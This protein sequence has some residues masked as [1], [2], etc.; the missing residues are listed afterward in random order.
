VS[1]L[2]S[3]GGDSGGLTFPPIR[4]KV[5]LVYT[6]LAFDLLN[7]RP[8]VCAYVQVEQFRSSLN[9]EYDD[10]TPPVPVDPSGS[11]IE[12][13][14]RIVQSGAASL[15]LASWERNTEMNQG[16]REKRDRGV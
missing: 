3:K 14:S 4:E 5:P 6:G 1:R 16:I 15:L 8:E 11:L 10:N 2:W 13:L 9:W 12:D 7:M